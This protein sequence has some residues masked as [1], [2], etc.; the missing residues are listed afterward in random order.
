MRHPARLRTEQSIHAIST[1]MPKQALVP[2][3]AETCKRCWVAG[4]TFPSLP[5]HATAHHFV[6]VV[7]STARSSGSATMQPAPLP[8]AANHDDGGARIPYRYVRE[9]GPYQPSFFCSAAIRGPWKR[10][11]PSGCNLLVGGT[12]RGFNGFCDVL[13]T[14]ILYSRCRPSRQTPIFTTTLLIKDNDQLSVA[15]SI[16]GSVMFRLASFAFDLMYGYEPLEPHAT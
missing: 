9:R 10:A 8:A 4:P 16:E 14:S 3:I 5:H 2:S 1:D 7:G 6:Q 13:H 11:R 15:E 12:T